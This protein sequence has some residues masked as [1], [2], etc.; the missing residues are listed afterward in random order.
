MAVEAY[1]KL[2]TELEEIRADYRVDKE[3]LEK[4]ESALK[5]RISTARE[6]ALINRLYT[7]LSGKVSGA[8]MDIETF[9]QRRFLEKILVSANKRFSSMSAGQ[10]ELR[11][12][13]LEKAGAGI[14]KGLNLMVYSYITGKSRD[15]RTLSGGESF[16]AA[17]SLA[18]GMADQIQ[19]RSGAVNLEMM[20]VDEGFGTLDDNSRNQAIKILKNMAGGSKLIG[21]ISHVNELKQEI[22]E[23]L[24][25]TKDEN[26]SKARWQLS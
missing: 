18:L 19:E 11:I 1:E 25:V 16:M 21:I 20:F 22:E 4:L 10:F 14:N 12:Y 9:V 24:I 23:Q 26:G 2:H 13:E 15:V 5:E 8:K 6:Y 17:L 3:I 7:R